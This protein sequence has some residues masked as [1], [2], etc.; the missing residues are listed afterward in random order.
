MN[1]KSSKNHIN[2]NK[3]KKNMKSLLFAEFK[4][5]LGN[6]NVKHNYFISELLNI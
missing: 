5:F 6:K 2:L 1:L 3:F 4:G